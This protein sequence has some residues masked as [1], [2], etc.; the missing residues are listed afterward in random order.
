MANQ[1]EWRTK[2]LALWLLLT[3][4]YMGTV[5]LISD[6]SAVKLPQQISWHP[7]LASLGDEPHLLFFRG[8]PV[9]KPSLFF[10]ALYAHTT[11][12]SSPLAA[13]MHDMQYDMTVWRAYVSWRVSRCPNIV[14]QR[15][16]IARR[17]C[18]A[19]ISTCLNASSVSF[20]RVTS[21]S[22]WPAVVSCIYV[23]ARP[24]MP[25]RTTL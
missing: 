6:N 3:A 24:C 5:Y 8:F 25:L 23:C 12:A 19:C 14:Q 17:G 7:I 1:V 15:I 11:A 2:L 20:L 16:C 9:L 10:T 18:P 21:Q 22:M 4:G 13:H